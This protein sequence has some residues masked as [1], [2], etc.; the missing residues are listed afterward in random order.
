[1]TSGTISPQS[2]VQ[3]VLASAVTDTLLYHEQTKHHFHRCVKSAG[4][5]DWAIQ[6][7][8]FRC[9]EGVTAVKLP[10]LQK[11]PARE[12]L[13][14]YENSRNAFE[15][16]TRQTIGAFLELSLGLSAWKSN[17]ED[18]WALRV[19]PCSGNLHPTEAHLI[20]PTLPGVTAGVFHCNSSLHALE[21][22]RMLKNPAPVVG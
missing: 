21:P 4:F 22:M 7:N 20:L 1:M 17:P 13:A 14:L 10:L 19:N 9:Y 3:Q 8:P 18:S 12:H 6:P 16:F 2:A 15:E 5:L 11:D